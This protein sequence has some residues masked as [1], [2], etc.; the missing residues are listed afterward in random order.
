M[1]TQGCRTLRFTHTEWQGPQ[2]KR[3]PYPHLP[4]HRPICPALG[5]SA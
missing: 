2:L 4:Y 3:Q 1:H 5:T